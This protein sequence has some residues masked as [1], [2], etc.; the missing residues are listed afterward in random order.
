MW[1]V[2]RYAP[3]IEYD[4]HAHLGLDLLDWFRGRYRWDKLL[5][6]LE[7]L[8]DGS[9]YRAAIAGDD[10]LAQRHPTTTGTKPSTPPRPPLTGYT[11]AQASLDGI[12][13]TL[14]LLVN[15]TSRAHGGKPGRHK[16]LP[17]PETAA[18]R[19][20]SGRTMTPSEQAGL[21]ELLDTLHTMGRL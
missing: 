19:V 17:T 20:R 14:R 6:L 16:P 2:D 8:P 18:D 7:Q 12:W 1:T 10:D 4:L 21:T 11:R 5:R 13:D 9:A 15:L 3:A